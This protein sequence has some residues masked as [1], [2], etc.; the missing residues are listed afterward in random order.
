MDR[1][2][3]LDE[4]ILGY[5]QVIHERYQHDSLKEAYDLPASFDQERVDRFRDFFL[6]NIYPKPEKRDELNE[7]FDSLDEYIKSPEKLLRLLVESAK[8]IFK[9]GRHLPKI[10]SAGMKALRSFRSANVFEGKLVDQAIASGKQPPFDKNDIEGFIGA[11]NKSDIES[12]IENSKSLFETL[13]DRELVKKISEIVEHLIDSMKSQP[14]H[15]SSQEISGLELGRDII[16][17]GDALFTQLS[18]EEQSQIFEFV[19]DLE[20]NIIENLFSSEQ[21]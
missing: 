15:Y 21:S 17:G 8:L 11:L 5:R 13:H 19:I 2:N 10:L 9:Y 6:E 4:V 20:K 1:K 12:F 7:A 14:Q 16:K 3:I 18:V